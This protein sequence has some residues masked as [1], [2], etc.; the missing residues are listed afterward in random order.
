MDGL[1]TG[2]TSDSGFNLTAT[3]T[4]N[5]LRFISV[6]M[7]AETSKKR[8]QDTSSLLD[9]G[10]NNYKLITLYKSG[11]LITTHSFEDS[12]NQNTPVIAKEDI[13]YLIK[14]NENPD[15]INVQ[16]EIS[17]Y[18]APISNNQVIGT[19]TVTNSNTGTKT[20]FNLYA[21]ENV[22]RLKF[23]D[24]LFKYWKLLIS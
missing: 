5:N 12:K 13:T 14:K 20:H 19:L 4:R 6:V 10:F 18:E 11:E 2:Y 15:K 23:M 7:G 16:I 17:K 24:I 9:Y 1:K 8:N 21:K 3:A 22:E